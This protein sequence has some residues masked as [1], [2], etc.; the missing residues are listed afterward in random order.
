V[1]DIVSS[2]VCHVRRQRIGEFA[3]AVSAW[4]ELLYFFVG[5]SG[6]ISA[7][8]E[9]TGADASVVTPA[10]VLPAQQ[11]IRAFRMRYELSK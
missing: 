5:T 6:L 9:V 3:R 11:L 1:R 2:G 8:T 4:A 10:P 7:L